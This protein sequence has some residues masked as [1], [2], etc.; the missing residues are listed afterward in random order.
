MPRKKSKK[1][2][3]RGSEQRYNKTP[4]YSSRRI[5]S[6]HYFVPLS[7]KHFFGGSFLMIMVSFGLFL[8]FIT[9]QHNLTAFTRQVDVTKLV[10]A[11][12]NPFTSIVLPEMPK[13]TI[14]RTEAPKVTTALPS[15]SALLRTIGLSIQKSSL[16]L[17][18]FLNPQPFMSYIMNTLKN[19]SSFMVQSLSIAFSLL[20]KI[21]MTTSTMLGRFLISAVR[22]A[23]PIPVVSRVWGIEI[24]IIRFFI[25]LAMDGIKLTGNGLFILLKLSATFIMTVFRFMTYIILGIYRFIVGIILGIGSAIQGFFQ[26]IGNRIKAVKAF[27]SPYI[28]FL[29]GG[30]SEAVNAFK[31]DVHNFNSLTA[32]I[33][34]EYET[35]KANK[36]RE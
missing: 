23:N 7:S 15:L 4:V 34:Q 36:I 20:I 32:D 14:P 21:T 9:Y 22:L 28:S 17:A 2:F 18:T 12:N 11:L 1:L 6:S 16:W 35:N 3:R 10:P 29:A 8:T 25:Q 19:V 24:T 5:N 31:T 30:M 26:A 13:V 27:F 33:M